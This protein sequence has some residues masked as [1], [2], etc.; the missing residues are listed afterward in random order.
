VEVVPVF[1]TLAVPLSVALI[2]VA[3]YLRARRR[4]AWQL[5]L[6]A[7]ALLKG[8]DFEEAVLSWSAAALLWSGRGAFCVRHRPLGRPSAKLVVV[9]AVA[10]ASGSVLA[11]NASALEL[12]DELEWLPLA[13]GA[14]GVV[15]CSCSPTSSSGRWALRGSARTE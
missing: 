4:R 2:V 12:H 7:V 6:G 5:A 15:G 10:V 1:H 9:A 11:W 8:L 13:V 14:A 3:F